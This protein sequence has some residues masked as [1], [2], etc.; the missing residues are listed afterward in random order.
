[1]R[2]LRRSEKGRRHLAVL[3]RIAA[4]MAVEEEEAR[5]ALAAVRARYRG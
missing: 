5:A 1:L 4:G 2:N 3:A